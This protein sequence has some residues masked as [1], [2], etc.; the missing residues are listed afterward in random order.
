MGGSASPSTQT[1]DQAIAW[2]VRLTSG[3]EAEADWNAF[4]LWLE[5]NPGNRIAYDRLEAI[6]PEVS[7]AIANNAIRSRPRS[8][9]AGATGVLRSPYAWLGAGA[10]LAAGLTLFILAPVRE[11]QI[12]GTTYSTNIRQTR[13]V[14]LADGSEADLNTDTEMTA[15]IAGGRRRVVVDHGE[16]LFHVAKDPA[17]PFNVLLGNQKVRVLG[18]VFD[19]V[20]TA[21]Q[22]RV[23]VAE[24][25]V[26]FSQADGGLPTPLSAG[27]QLVYR[28]GSGT[29]LRHV[30]A[31]AASAW[32]SGYLIYTDATL[33]DVVADL[34]RYFTRKIVIADAIAAHQRFSGVLRIDSE[35]AMLHRLSRLLPVKAAST[36]NG[37]LLLRTR[38]LKD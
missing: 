24:G 19:V 16:V 10:A 12:R 8:I 17:H 5:S 13:S 7:A 34:N 25:H 32:R 31:S 36:G 1:V 35:E 6:L 33:A 38:T 4:T 15:E 30:P 28:P 2:H 18:T 27:D 11:P 29:H 14:H 23:T 20:R 9:R 21:D 37:T 22:T 26:Q 3:G